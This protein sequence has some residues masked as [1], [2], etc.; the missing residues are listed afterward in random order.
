[1]FYFA[2]FPVSWTACPLVSPIRS[3]W[4]LTPTVILGK[5]SLVSTMPQGRCS[6]QQPSKRKPKWRQCYGP[7]HGQTNWCGRTRPVQ[8]R[9]TTSQHQVFFKDMFK[10]LHTIPVTSSELT[11]VA[12]LA[13]QIPSALECLQYTSQI[14]KSDPCSIG[15][16]IFATVSHQL[17]CHCKP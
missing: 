1:M 5:G 15:S 3:G 6:H 12:R 8:Q 17:F 11:R 2:K 16:Y 9:L 13:D 14:S 10:S 4:P 7:D